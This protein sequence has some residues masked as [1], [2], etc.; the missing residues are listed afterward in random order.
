MLIHNFAIRIFG[1]ALLLILALV[2]LAD[3]QLAKAQDIVPLQLYWSSQR[4]DNFVTATHQGGNAAI[5]A[6]YR[7][8]R[9]EACIFSLQK[10][11][12]IPFNLYWSA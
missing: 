3:V 5:A 11:G 8:V 4:G 9:D 12:T 2:A 10:P 7:Y 6:G 1:I